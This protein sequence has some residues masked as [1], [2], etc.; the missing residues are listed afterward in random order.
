MGDGGAPQEHAG[1]PP[2]EDA[3]LPPAEDG[4]PPEEDVGHPEEDAGPPEEG[5]ADKEKDSGAT[6][7]MGGGGK[8]SRKQLFFS[9]LPVDSRGD[10]MAEIMGELIS[11]NIKIEEVDLDDCE[12]FQEFSACPRS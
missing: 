2:E 7:Q 5:A 4:E 8:S 10:T 3:G 1:P 11:R 9:D 6:D 12:F